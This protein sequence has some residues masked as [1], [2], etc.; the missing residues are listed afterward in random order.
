MMRLLPLLLLL[1]SLT[2]FAQSHTIHH[3]EPANWW[4]GMKYHQ[5]EL[6]V[7]GDNISATQPHIDYP[8]VKILSVVKTD[9]PNYV[10]VTIDIAANTKPGKFPIEFQLNGETQSRFEY[11]LLAREKQSAQRQGFSA[12]DAIYLITPDRFANGNPA[13]DA[14]PGL[15]EQPNRDYKGGRHGGDIAGMTQHLDY[16][17]SMGFTQIW[18]NPLTENNQPKY[19]YHGYAATNLYLIDA[20]YGTNEDFKRFVQKAKQKGIGV[21]QDIVLNHIG[22]EH[23]WMKDLPASDWLN[24][25][26]APEFTNHRRTTVQDPYADPRDKELFVNGWF[27]NSMPDLNQRNPQMANYLIQNSLWWIEYAGLSGVR[28]DTYGYADEKFLSRWAK[29]IMDEYPQ[30]NIVG[31]EWSTNPAVVAHWQRGKENKSGHVSHM[32]SVMDFPIHETLRHV[33]VEEESWDKGLVRLYEMLANDFVYA[34]PFNLVVFPENHDTSRIYSV[35]N[36]D[37][38]LFKTAMIYSAT[39]R[40]IPQFYYGSEVLLTSP[41]E[42][43]DGAVRADMPGGWKG[44][45]KNAFTGKGLTSKE[46]EAQQFMK[47][48]LTWRKKS[49]VIHRGHLRHYAPENGVYVYVR[50][51][52]NKAVMVLLNKNKQDTTHSLAAYKEFLNGKKTMR[53]VLANKKIAV[54]DSLVLPAKTS[55]V[56][57]LQ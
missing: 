4:V 43:D 26:G 11:A 36:E 47:T 53:D 13:N 46:K 6:M 49:E 15:T 33:L 8:G 3:L 50:Y 45:S 27:V 28:E 44:D 38:D 12:K 56:L 21:I 30:F 48:L 19:S 2:A 52:N 35:L 20:R 32:P 23:W 37:V 51:L 41:K 40:G 17:A 24:F 14:M 29:A 57:E 10:F 55:L 22:S 16:I 7:H 1:C 39:M 54:S 42:R 9:N 5:V 18:P 25:Q 34:D 31:E